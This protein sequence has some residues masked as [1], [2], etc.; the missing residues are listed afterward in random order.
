MIWIK[1]AAVAVLLL[2]SGSA[3]AQEASSAVP[4]AA[5]GTE[6]LFGDPM[7]TY[8]TCTAAVAMW[9]EQYSP[10]SLTTVTAGPIE[11]HFSGERV[12]P[13]FVKVIYDTIGGPETRKETVECTV[14]EGAASVVIMDR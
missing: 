7:A 13:L 9:A 12:A 3:D 11:W 14:S 6:Y 8:H 1:V 10:I 2:G 4:S 5:K